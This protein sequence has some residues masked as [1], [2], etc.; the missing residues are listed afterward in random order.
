[1]FRLTWFPLS[2]A[3]SGG[4]LVDLG[5][6]TLKPHLL[7]STPGEIPR[8]PV[9]SQTVIEWRCITVIALDKIAQKI[10]DKLGKPEM[11]TA[12]ILE[13]A[14]WKAGRLVAK[15]KREGGGPPIE[16]ISDG[17]VF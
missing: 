16:I 2:A 6:L 11:T 13:A 9:D 3:P 7:P 15:E 4:L 14:T 1:L 12:Q 10:K 5:L 8:F 17:T